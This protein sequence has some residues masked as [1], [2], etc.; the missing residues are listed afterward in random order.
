LI[1]GSMSAADGHEPVLGGST[2]QML[3]APAW[4]T[5]RVNSTWRIIKATQEQNAVK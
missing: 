2:D 3:V 4:K 5:K 1:G